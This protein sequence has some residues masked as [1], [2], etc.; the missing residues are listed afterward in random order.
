MTAVNVLQSLV[1]ALCGFWR[2]DSFLRRRFLLKGGRRRVTAYFASWAPA[3]IGVSLWIAD[4][5]FGLS[6]W[7]SVGF[8]IVL[9]LIL[10]YFCPSVR[11]YLCEP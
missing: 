3:I 4:G 11:K 1:G 9:L 8:G 5:H 7:H 2:G 10:V 6:W